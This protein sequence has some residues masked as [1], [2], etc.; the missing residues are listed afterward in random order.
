MDKQQ[1]RNKFLKEH[2]NH[3]TWGKSLRLYPLLSFGEACILGRAKRRREAEGDRKAFFEENEHH[4]SGAKETREI[5]TELGYDKEF[6]QKVEHCVL[7]HRGRK[8]PAPETKEAEI[9]ACADAMSHFNT[10]LD[11]FSFFLSTTNSFDEA[12]N[13]IEKKM[14][15]NWEKKLTIPEAKEMVRDKYEA[16]KLLISS[17]KE[18]M[19]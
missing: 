8:G 10:F 13:K 9:I 1:R 11:L 16:I 6:I 19:N 3:I 17:M 7:A 15:R 4:I 5:L 2:P 14:E 18:R 12:V